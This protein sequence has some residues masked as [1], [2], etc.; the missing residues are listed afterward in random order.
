MASTVLR[1]GLAAHK[2]YTVLWKRRAG[3]Q[4]AEHDD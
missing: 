3:E 1:T 4:Q 2:E